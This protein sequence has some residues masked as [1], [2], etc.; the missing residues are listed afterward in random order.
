MSLTTGRGP[1]SRSPAGRLDRCADGATTYV[2]P[3][4]RRVRARV[5]GRTVIDCE[6]V[7]LVHR[8]GQ[9]PAYAFPE[10]DVPDDLLHAAE[11]SAP[12]H[13]R[14]PWDA[15][16]DWY[17]EEERVLGHPRNPYHRIDCLQVRRRLRVELHGVVLVDTADVVGMY[18][19]SR[20]PQLYASRQATRMDLLAASDTVTYCP[21]KGAATYWTAQVR[22]R[23]VEDVA[24]SYDDPLPECAAV[25]GMLS[26]DP[27][28]AEVVQEVPTWFAVP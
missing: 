2:E 18:E 15:V 13:V 25:A 5:G 22:G 27:A 3:L 14:V 28:R 17:E 8:S 21:Y 7:L 1:H 12:G 6:R 19:T 24:W 26:F 4:L 23:V 11:P 16:G 10:G 20:L 9:P